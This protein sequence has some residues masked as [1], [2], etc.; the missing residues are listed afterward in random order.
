MAL[1]A[2]GIPGYPESHGCVHLPSEF[3]RLLFGVAPKGMTVVIANKSSAPANVDHP[4]LLVPVTAAGTASDTQRLAV[5]ENYRWE[6]EKSPEG[7]VSMIISGYDK[8][9]I[10]LRNGVE[11]G[12]ATLT[13]KDPETPL[14]THAFV[15]A[16]VKDG[17]DTRGWIGLAITGHMDDSNRPPDP[18]ATKRINLPDAFIHQLTP[19]LAVGSTM[20]ITDEPALESTTGVHMSV[21]SSSADDTGTASKM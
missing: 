8:R 3:A 17:A 10:V 9:V 6:P 15:M 5:S 19:L 18:D 1:H 4:P 12:R 21:L 13:L 14:G 2:G 20:M 7:P 11:I 16:Q